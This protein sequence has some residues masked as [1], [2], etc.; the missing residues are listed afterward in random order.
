MNAL[1]GYTGLVGSWLTQDN[2]FNLQEFYNS[3]NYQSAQNRSF[4]NV[5]FAA[6]PAAKW[7]AN[8]NHTEDWNNIQKIINVLK[9]VKVSG[10]FILIST[11][12]VYHN[13]VGSETNMQVAEHAYGLHRKR[14]EDFVLQQFPK[15]FILRLP[16]LFGKGLKKNVLFD[17]LNDNQIEKIPQNSFFQWYDLKWL[18][19]DI[20]LLLQNVH[21][22]QHVQNFV[23]EPIYT[24]EIIKRFF[25][26]Q[27]SPDKTTT[28]R[29]NVTTDQ[30]K[31][32]YLKMKDEVYQAMHQY[33][34]EAQQRKLRPY[35]IGVSTIALSGLDIK[36]K[37]MGWLFF[38]GMLKAFKVDYCEMAPTV[39]A[40]WIEYNEQSL[41][42][43]NQTF[44]V[45]S[46]QSITYT[47]N[48]NLFNVVQRPALLKHL[49]YVIKNSPHRVLVFGCPKNRYV[50]DG[51]TNEHKIAIDFFRVLGELAAEKDVTICLENNSSKYGCNFL[52]TV[53]EVG[54]FVRSV[55]HPNIRMMIDV[56]NALM[57]G[58]NTVCAQIR[59]NID[60][61]G[62]FHV[63]A[64][65]M[66][67]PLFKMFHKFHCDIAQQLQIMNY[68]GGVTLEMLC[69]NRAEFQANLELFTTYY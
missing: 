39:F 64:P 58:E 21:I 42:R 37:E 44:P 28:I 62:H 5:F 56:G 4:V 9:T 22:Q 40:P 43:R 30:T 60:I 11:V 61:L 53:S 66:R 14:F 38:T 33:I 59:D 24:G 36:D 2:R 51:M 6:L 34:L 67:G 65:Y 18:N 25:P 52:T 41:K 63:S 57:E 7:Y 19:N 16:A 13:G 10:Y 31:T 47:V 3:K 35:K 54:S 27:L 29:Y 32:G 26:K 55:N 15:C 23:S 45:Y 50:P 69:S 20:Y 68:A 17:L 46:L 49:H 8:Q 1:F 48:Y 12:D